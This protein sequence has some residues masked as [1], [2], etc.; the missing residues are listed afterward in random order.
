MLKLV[1]VLLTFTAGALDVTA[2]LALDHVFASV[3][4]GNMV[5]LGLAGATADAH[6]A[7]SAGL[8]FI[9]YAAGA[10]TG[11][12]TAEAVGK[13][14]TSRRA[15]VAVLALELVTLLAFG[16]VWLVVGG[17]AEA[18]VS[19]RRV[20]L[21]LAAASMGL[22]SSAVKAMGAADLSTTYLTGTLTRLLFALATRHGKRPD[23]WD[24]LRLLALI[25]GA[26]LTGLVLHGAPRLMPVLPWGVFAVALAVAG[27]GP[28]RAVTPVTEGGRP[29]N[30]ARDG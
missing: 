26:A 20:L 11:A 5:L 27:L 25:A 3:M 17:G 12:R 6:Q 7:I 29:V 21:V 9:G 23:P 1:P 15:V 13:G 24:G 22:Q 2:F 30:R 8:A 10:L 18:A 19:L 16:I 28:D 4:T 14:A